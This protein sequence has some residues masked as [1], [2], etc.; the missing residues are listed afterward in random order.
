M[1][2]E[3]GRYVPP[4]HKPRSKKEAPKR[5]LDKLNA[6][7]RTAILSGQHPKLFNIGDYVEGSEDVLSGSGLAFLSACSFCP[8]MFQVP[9]SMY[10]VIGAWESHR[11]RVPSCVVIHAMIS[12]SQVAWYKSIHKSGQ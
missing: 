4:A 3:Q 1:V 11:S 9:G 12:A 10:H 8:V 6:V 2:E 5:E 7:E